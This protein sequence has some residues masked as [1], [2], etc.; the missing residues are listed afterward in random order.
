MY[1]ERARNN[2]DYHALL[3]KMILSSLSL[4]YKHRKM[5]GCRKFLFSRV[6]CWPSKPKYKERARNNNDY[7][8]LLTKMILSSLSLLYKHRKM[9]GC[10]KFL[11]N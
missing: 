6:A 8:A 4:R 7:H 11:F 10:G 2:N 1:K 3:T 5:H 9:H